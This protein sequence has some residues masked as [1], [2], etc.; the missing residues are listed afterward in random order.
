M[1]F[2][3]IFATDPNGVVGTYKN[4]KYD[5][6]FK[7]KKDFD[8]FK[9][10]TMNQCVIMGHNTYRAIGKPLPNR[11][12]IVLSS[13]FIETD[14]VRVCSSIKEALVVAMLNGYK[15]V[16]FI[17]GVNVLEQVYAFLDDLYLTKYD[18]YVDLSKD[19]LV[20]LPKRRTDFMLR[21][22]KLFVDKD[23]VTGK[24][25]TGEFMHFKSLF[26]GEPK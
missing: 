17:G 18:Q 6:P 14:D 10:L 19:N 26:H 5:Q 25:L 4:G 21:E 24:T 1:K 8:W 15:E 9:N 20:F 11:F 23:L 22:S 12:N 3:A 13:Q 16:W 2:N 7:C